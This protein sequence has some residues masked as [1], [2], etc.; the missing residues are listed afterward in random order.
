MFWRGVSVRI[1]LFAY[2]FFIP[3]R[4]FVIIMIFI[5]STAIIWP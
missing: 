5:R 4:I 1:C 2:I 3:T